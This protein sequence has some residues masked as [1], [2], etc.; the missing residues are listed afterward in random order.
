MRSLL[1]TK[2]SEVPHGMT[3]SKQAAQ[4][5]RD[6]ASVVLYSSF[7]S[8]RSAHL[9]PNQQARSCCFVL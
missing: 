4:A 9:V 1:M 6:W 8:T 5:V 2:K 3:V 7:P